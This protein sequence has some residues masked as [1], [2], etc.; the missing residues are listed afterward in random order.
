MN[1]GW[2]SV[3]DGDGMLQEKRFTQQAMTWFPVNMQMATVLGYSF[4]PGIVATITEI[5]AEA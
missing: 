2:I 4:R 3:S 5:A 1:L